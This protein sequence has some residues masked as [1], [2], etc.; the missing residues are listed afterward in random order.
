[1]KILFLRHSELLKISLLNMERHSTALDDL[2]I[3]SNKA[4]LNIFRHENYIN[5]AKKVYHRNMLS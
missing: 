1:M 2:T 3:N 4:S 5:F